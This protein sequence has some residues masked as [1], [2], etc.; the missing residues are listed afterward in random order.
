MVHM[1]A[2]PEVQL[3]ASL[4]S[5]RSYAPDSGVPQASFFNHEGFRGQG[6]GFRVQ[7]LGFRVQGLGFRSTKSP[8]PY[9]P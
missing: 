6:L 5:P 8:K 3:T 7:G 2:G 1:W 9:R 4:A